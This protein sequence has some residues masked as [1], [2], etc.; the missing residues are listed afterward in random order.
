MWG[1]NEKK[2]QNRKFF[3]I[4]RQSLA[5]DALL[6]AVVLKVVNNHEE[7]AHYL[8]TILTNGVDVQAYLDEELVPFFQKLEAGA[9]FLFGLS[10]NI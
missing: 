3:K 4:F 10:L 9:P 1:Q 8:L 2:G 5:K 7:E 6:G